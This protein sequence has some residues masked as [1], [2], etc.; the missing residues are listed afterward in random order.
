M[1]KVDQSVIKTPMGSNWLRAITVEEVDRYP[2]ATAK[3]LSA[4]IYAFL[5]N[6]WEL[7]TSIPI[8]GPPST[9]C[10]IFKKKLE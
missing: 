7:V 8:F 9:I 5:N 4:T 1:P 3:K 2:E 10:L 6:G